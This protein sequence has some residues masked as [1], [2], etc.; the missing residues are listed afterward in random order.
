MDGVLMRM[1]LPAC[2]PQAVCV[3]FCY[4]SQSNDTVLEKL[5]GILS[6]TFL[7]IFL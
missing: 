7:M 4:T 1:P 5:L 6:N 3:L 2:S